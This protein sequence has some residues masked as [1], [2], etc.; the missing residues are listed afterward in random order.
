MKN[1]NLRYL[2]AP[3]GRRKGEVSPSL[4]EELATSELENNFP[5][6]IWVKRSG[7]ALRLLG[8]AKSGFLA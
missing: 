7:T 1:I 2:I 5:G 8:S 4:S 6:G 3:N